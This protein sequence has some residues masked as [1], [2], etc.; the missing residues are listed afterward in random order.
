MSRKHIRIIA[1]VVAAI[2]LI[3]SVGIV[4]VEMFGGY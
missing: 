3:T 1:I 4:G 2:F